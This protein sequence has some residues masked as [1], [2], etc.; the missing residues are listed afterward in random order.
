MEH[1][2]GSDAVA[3]A[4][5]ILA[6]AGN[7]GHLVVSVE[8]SSRAIRIRD[9]LAA[10]G[11]RERAAFVVRQRDH[12]GRGEGNAAAIRDLSLLP[13]SDDTESRSW[14]DEDIPVYETPQELAKE[15]RR[16][17]AEAEACPV[18]GAEQAQ[19]RDLERMRRFEEEMR[20]CSV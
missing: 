18:C 2:T 14:A 16:L 10:E 3:L 8:D 11:M 7:T 19:E 15:I 4:R 6:A 20:R 5:A 12:S 17:K 13:D 9:A 1:P